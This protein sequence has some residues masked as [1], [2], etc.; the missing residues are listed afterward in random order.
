VRRF[1]VV[2][3]AVLAFSTPH[4]AGAEQPS[5]AYV[6]QVGGEHAIY[7]PTEVGGPACQTD[8]G[9]TACFSGAISADASGKVTGTAV[10]EFSGD[11]EGDL[12]ATFSGRLS[13][14]T[15]D[16]K[17]RLAMHMT[18]EVS[19]GGALLD[20]KARGRWRC[21]E[22]T[23]LGGFSC[24]GRLRRCMF[25]GGQRLGCESERSSLHLR[26]QGGLWAV[27]LEL[28]T[29]AK[30]IVGGTA[31]VFLSTGAVLDY[32]L[33]GKYNARTDTAKLRLVGTG[34]A[35][36]SELELSTLSLSNS[37]ATA[38][39][40]RYRIAGQKGRTLLPAPTSPRPFP[41]HGTCIPGGFCDT[42]SDTGGLFGG[43]GQTG[44]IADTIFFPILGGVSR[45]P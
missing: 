22:D 20:V 23:T 40:L 5:G 30:G 17:L 24:S 9:V 28:S 16:T 2:S 8:G 33:A 37:T 13:G 42:N 11:V 32:E 26:E 36:G 14:S 12:A 34:E 21:V 7:L 29:D 45:L 43:Q 18:G 19:S 15:A 38:G 1:A 44:T 3:S 35:Q 6:I 31:T 10:A 25:D 41:G 4:A 39:E 27:Y